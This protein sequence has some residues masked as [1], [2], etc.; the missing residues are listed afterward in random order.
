MVNIA[1]KS[2][3]YT[4]IY[5]MMIENI[6]DLVSIIDHNHPFKI[7]FIN[8]QV[9]LKLLKYSNDDLINE[10]ILNY[11]HPDDKEKAIKIFSKVLDGDL[12]LKEIRIKNLI[13]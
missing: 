5:E 13:R 8:E 11:L 6:N 7:K 12:D 3:E 10:S 4:D 1:D 2:F 9:F